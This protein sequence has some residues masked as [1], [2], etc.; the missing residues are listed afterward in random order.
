MKPLIKSLKPS[1]KLPL[2]EEQ[3]NKKIKS[4]VKEQIKK[5]IDTI[6]REINRKTIVYSILSAVG[7]FLVFAPLPQF[8]LYS[9]FFAMMPVIVYLLAEFIKSIRKF[10]DF[11]D[12]FDVKIKAIVESKIKKEK[13]TSL[14]SRIGFQLSGHDTESMANYLISCSVRELIYRFK[15]KKKFVVMRIT[16]YTVIV[17]LFKE[18]FTNILKTL[19]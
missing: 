16:A 5:E 1:I 4:G 15:E 13:G 6:V 18:I 2:A 9:L 12:N 11:I 8:V 14:K 3:I 17:L 10:F 19:N 7:L